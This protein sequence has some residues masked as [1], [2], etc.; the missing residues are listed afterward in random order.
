[1]IIPDTLPIT[2]I[3][4][5]DFEMEFIFEGLNLSGYTVSSQLRTSESQQATLLADF[6]VVVTPGTN[7]TVQISLDDTTTGA[8]IQSSGW[9]D[10]LITDPSDKD[11]TYVRGPVSLIG[12][13]TE[14]P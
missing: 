8:L 4:G 9:Y 13:V 10:L 12:S 3:K 5:R 11:E 6:T 2:I 7:S 14:K 1:M